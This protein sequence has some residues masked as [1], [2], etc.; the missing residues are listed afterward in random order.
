MGCDIHVVFQAKTDN[1]WVDIPHEY[2]ERRHYQLFAIL[3]GVRNG[4]GFAGV[5]TGTAVAPISKPRG[6]PDD[7]VLV[8]DPETLADYDGTPH[9]DPLSHPVP[10]AECMSPWR[11]KYAEDDGLFVWMGDHS[12]SWLTADEILGYSFP[13]VVQCGVI[14]RAEFAMWDGTKPESYSGDIWGQGVKVI[15]ANED[16][17][18]AAMAGDEYTH[19][20]VYWHQSTLDE[21]KYFVDEVQR[22][23]DEHGNVRMVFGFDS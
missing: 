11:R 9:F 6:V 1:G 14:S 8:H 21:V 17:D 3:A 16:K 18:I 23:K 10:S 7:F 15:D 5:P 13:E 12:H 19:V 20:R 2:E 22:L 4:I